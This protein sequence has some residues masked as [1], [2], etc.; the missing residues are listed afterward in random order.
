MTLTLTDTDI[1]PDILAFIETLDEEQ[2]P[3]DG[4]ECPRT[5][6]WL[7]TCR[8]CNSRILVC[9]EHDGR[10]RALAAAGFELSCGPCGWV[11]SKWFLVFDREP[12]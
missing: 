6:V 11:A 3:C 8:A 12:L 4:V 5:P 9:G 2:E 10:L 7:W 1:D